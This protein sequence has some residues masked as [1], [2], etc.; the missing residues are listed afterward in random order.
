M[1][2]G[3][4]LTVQLRYTHTHAHKVFVS[5]EKNKKNGVRSEVDFSAYNS[6]NIQ[7]DQKVTQPILK[8]LL[9]VAIQYNL[10][11]LINTQCRC[12]Y[13]SPRRSHH[14]GTC[15]C[16]SISCLSTVEV[17]GCLFLKCN[18]CSLSNTT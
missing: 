15:S 11:G 12:D 9:M 4:L 13:K 10:I 5:E 3:W 16:Q 7:D 6:E 17:Q 2:S 14:V 18:E 8:Y 1:F